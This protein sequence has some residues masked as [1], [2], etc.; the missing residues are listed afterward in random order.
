MTEILLSL[1]DSRRL[2]GPN[3]FGYEAGV[4][5][6]V[7][8]KGCDKAAVVNRWQIEIK[9]LL[10]LLG[11]SK[12]RTF[13]RIS[14]EGAS[15]GF[16][17]PIDVLYAATEV[18]EA[19]W[20]LTEDYFLKLQSKPISAVLPAL[21]ALIAAEANPALLALQ[22]AAKL[23]QVPFLSDDELVSLGYGQ[24]CQVFPVQQI[25]EVAT[26]NWSKIQSIPLALVTGTNGKST[27]VRLAAHVVKTAGKKCGVT[28]TDYIRIDDQVLDTGDY[29]GPGGARTL[30]RHPE[31]EVA[32]LEVA[33]G[34]M[35]RRGLGVNQASCAAITNVAADHLGDYG[36][37]NVT[38]MVAAKFVVRQ[39]L[40]A[41]QDLILNADDVQVVDCA[42][43]L[44][45]TIVWFSCSADNPVIQSHISQGGKAVYV[46]EG[47]IYYHEKTAVEVVSE[48]DI[49][50]TMNGA[51]KHNTQNAMVVTAMMF[52]L[53]VDVPAIR[54]GLTTFVNSPANN[55]G[56]GNVF[57]VNGF[58][59][60]VDFAHNAH[61]M[62]A[63]A[64]TIRSM[65]AKRRLIMLGQA[66]DRNNELIKSL[67]QSALIAQPDCLVVCE[68]AHYLRG[69][70]AGEVPALIEQYALELGMKKQQIIHANSSLQGAIAA[71]QWAQPE[72]VL[73][74]LSLTDRD[75]VIRL[76]ESF[77]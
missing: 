7:T 76:V 36:M 38:D 21:E 53:G 5:I 3:L 48:G 19:A 9:Q 2:T 68:L 32:I 37:D 39:A 17:A 43:G 33:R 15:V 4:V 22:Q 14:I 40:T 8:I 11:W 63:M 18:N 23:H 55:P 66:G 12:Q 6:E 67:V 56:R 50:I 26:I 44:N 46:R 45:N 24:S 57:K 72:D 35:L 34:G 30:L 73:L 20:Q 31:T 71:L 58:T 16:T 49:P 42:Q 77:K 59:A 10:S 60:L 74:L 52:A 13:S 41:S 70:Q 75:E 51:A 69:R 28:S 29:S 1:N 64:N 54:L 62:A 25:P 61:G 27:T 65:P 47:V